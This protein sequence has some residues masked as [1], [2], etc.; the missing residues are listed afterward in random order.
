MELQNKNIKNEKIKKDSSGSDGLT[1]DTEIRNNCFDCETESTISDTVSDAAGSRDSEQQKNGR[2]KKEGRIK[3]LRRNGFFKK[4]FVVLFWV[5]VSSI[6]VYTL[7][8]LSPPFAEFWARYLSLPI[9]FILAKISDIFQFS[10]AEWVIISLPLIAI[11]YIAA[12][13]HSTK[14]DESPQNFYKWIRAP[15]S[16]IMAIGIIFF[17][18]FG[19]SYGRYRLSENLG[20]EQEKVS[21]QDL[22]D[23]AVK[24]NDLLSEELDSIRFGDGGASVMPY[25]YDTLVRK[26]NE[27]FEKYAEKADY[28]TYFSSYPKPIALSGPMTYTHISGVYTFMTG[29]SNININYP[30]FLI[31]YTMAHEMSHQRG[32]A[33]EDEANFV[34]FLVCLESDDSYIR[35]SGY[36]NMLDYLGDALYSADKKLYSEFRNKYMPQSLKNEYSSFSAFF[37][38][39]ADSTASHVTGSVN[40]AFLQS[41]GQSHGIKSYGLVVDLAVAYFKQH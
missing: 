1:Q 36:A 12:S 15:L 32:I 10:I 11:F 39:Y 34:A 13:F 19:P 9:R 35:Y 5:F 38:K 31:P 23:T 22:Y 40:N 17:A 8:R 18:G 16:L 41:Q 33:R 27:A 4:Y 20:I 6:L 21:A 2:K 26:T 28:I 30:D 14:K 7:S 29:E 37:R 24:V 3:R 25:G